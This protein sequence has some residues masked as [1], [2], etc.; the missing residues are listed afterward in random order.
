[1]RAALLAVV[2]VGLAGCTVGSTDP[3]SGPTGQDAR[4]AV[5]KVRAEWEAELA[6]G[7]RERPGRRFPNLSRQ[8]FLGRLRAAAARNDFELVD[9]DFLRPKQLAPRVVVQSSDAKALARA[10][11]RFWRSI[12]PKA[13]TPDD[14]IGWAFEGFL[15]EA[16]D[17]D[18]IPA[19]VVFHWWR[20]RESV[21]GGQWARNEALYPFA[22]G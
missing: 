8:E 4:R 7:V 1:M 19:F 15:F 17:S 2:V 5:E 3:V 21:G 13:T 10:Y 20:A 18:G 9:V 16:R 14:R 11:G 12:D 6:R 22:H